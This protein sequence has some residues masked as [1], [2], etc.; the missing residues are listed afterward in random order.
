METLPTRK[1]L[2]EL[3]YWEPEKKQCE[4]IGDS[5]CTTLSVAG[6]EYCTYHKRLVENRIAAA[7]RRRERQL[8]QDR[9]QR[10]QLD[11]QIKA[12]TRIC[13]LEGTISLRPSI[14]KRANAHN[15]NRKN[16]KPK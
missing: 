6:E 10:L 14:I 11:M 3:I 15:N 13:E 16:K 4:F 5:Q 1:D 8:A 12:H 9:L 2:Y 7:L